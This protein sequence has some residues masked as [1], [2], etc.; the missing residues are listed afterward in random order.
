MFR[1]STSSLAST[2][3]SQTAQSASVKKKN[4]SRRDT[5]GAKKMCT[6]FKRLSI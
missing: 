3:T 2:Y 6:H 5:E 4:P 1:W